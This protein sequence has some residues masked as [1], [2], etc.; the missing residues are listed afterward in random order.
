MGISLAWLYLQQLG[1]VDLTMIIDNPRQINLLHPPATINNTLIHHIK[2]RRP[3]D[4]AR[5]YFGGRF[6]NLKVRW[7]FAQVQ[8]TPSR[9]YLHQTKGDKLRLWYANPL[10][11]L[12][13]YQG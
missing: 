6:A 1:V 3:K 13:A 8:T 7:L 10:T 4:R 2:Q 11:A 12:P 5:R 9:L